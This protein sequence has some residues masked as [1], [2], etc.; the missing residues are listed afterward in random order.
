[1]AID[2]TEWWCPTGEEKLIICHMIDEVS[3]LSSAKLIQNKQ[4]ETII[5]VL[6]EKWIS[7]YGSSK[8]IVH[9]RREEFENAKMNTFLTLMG[10]RSAS[11]SAYSPFS[12]GVV[13]RHNSV[14]KTTMNKLLTTHRG[15]NGSAN[16]NIVLQHSVFA[17][18][19]LLDFKGYSPLMRVYG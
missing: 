19:A 2:L 3:R 14:L 9:D 15:E 11:T 16:L 18:I 17:K 1:M 5:D 13:E 6:M 12:N 8:R 10:V 4:P 7:V